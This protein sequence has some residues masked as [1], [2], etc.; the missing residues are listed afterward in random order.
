MVC[1]TTAAQVWVHHRKTLSSKIPNTS[2]GAVCSGAVAAI[3]LQPN[4]T[5][6]NPTQP[7]CPGMAS[8]SSPT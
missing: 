1:Q 6:P 5:K 8:T 4:P 3:L 2:G 7:T